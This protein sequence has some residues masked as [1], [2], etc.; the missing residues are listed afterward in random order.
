MAFDYQ[1]AAVEKDRRVAEAEEHLLLALPLAAPRLTVQGVAVAGPL[2]REE[3]P[4]HVIRVGHRPERR[5]R[6]RQPA[7]VAGRRQRGNA[8]DAVH[9][10]VAHAAAAAATAARLPL[11]VGY[12]YISF[13]RLPFCCC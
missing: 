6:R 2:R 7:R 12:M 11:H 13:S 4:P 1:L 9:R 5:G 10:Q 3:A 8:R